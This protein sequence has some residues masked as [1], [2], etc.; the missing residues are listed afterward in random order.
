MKLLINYKARI[1]TAQFIVASNPKRFAQEFVLQELEGCR[2]T[3]KEI[4]VSFSL[5]AWSV[6]SRE[7]AVA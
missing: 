4:L 3:T 7:L 5:P 2:I 1:A 6:T